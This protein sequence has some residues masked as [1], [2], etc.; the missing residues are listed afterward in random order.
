M[1]APAFKLSR[2][3]NALIH[4]GSTGAGGK[5]SDFKAMAK[6]QETM[7]EDVLRHTYEGFL[8]PKELDD[9][10]AGKDYWL[11]GKQFSQR[12][13]NRQEVLQAKHEAAQRVAPAEE[14]PEE[15]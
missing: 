13:N 5:F 6:A 7:M 1:N 10:I 8:T 14:D 4:N 11:D 3:F 15:V 9:L 12:F 2:N